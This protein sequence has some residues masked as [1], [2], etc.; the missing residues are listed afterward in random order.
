MIKDPFGIVVT[1]LV[2]EGL[3]LFLA[4]Q[5]RTKPLFKYLPSM[6][7][8]YFLPMLA[9]TIG[10]I[11]PENV[12]GEQVTPVYGVIRD[13]CLPG[14]LLLLLISVDLRAIARLGWRALA[15]MLAGSAGIVIG[16]P[17]VLLL[18]GRWLPA[19]AWMGI[20]PLSASWTG[21]S[22]NLIAVAESIKTPPP[23]YQAIIVVDT[24]I[25]YAW[26]G[27]LVLLSGYQAYYDRWNRS[28]ATIVEN[29]KRKSL[30]SESRRHPLTLEHAAVMLALA[31]AATLIATRAGT[32][33]S[34]QI[35]G[36]WPDLPV[37]VDAYAWMIIVV[38][39]L[40]LALSF[41]PVRELEK[42]GAS[43]LGYALLYFVLA[44]IGAK[45][46]LLG[47]G[48]APML[49]AAGAT[50]VLIH[51]A[52]TVAAGRLVRAPMSLL[53]AASQANIGGVASA[54][55]VAGVYQQG[56]APVGLLMA[57]LGN[58]IGTYLGLLCTGLCRLVSR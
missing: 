40:G 44:S 8:I 25:P 41:T 11:P 29:L 4:E 21:G 16:G 57:I 24:I 43:R 56:L 51:A 42:Q 2:I 6:F 3:I 14:A 47:L 37:K 26:M 45:T 53:A 30:T 39:T 55:V 35:N 15:V 9:G 28:N 19:D 49:L 33:V 38:T 23:M 17:V 36:R 20:G 10:L 48:A 27:L 22:A 46:N 32:A 52:F 54:P 7:W 13:Y 12:G 31:A 1:L 18:F 34:A 58:I 50:W 5:R